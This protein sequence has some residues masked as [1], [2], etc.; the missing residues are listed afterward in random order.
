M[1]AQAPPSA[2][3]EVQVL[4]VDTIPGES[5]FRKTHHYLP[6]RVVDD[7]IKFAI[8]FGHDLDSSEATAFI[9][10]ALDQYTE[11]RDGDGDGD[12]QGDHSD[13][14]GDDHGDDYGNGNDHVPGLTYTPSPAVV[15]KPPCVQA[16][17]RWGEEPSPQAS[18]VPS[19]P[20]SPVNSD[21][22]GTSNYSYDSDAALGEQGLGETSEA[23]KD[24]M[25][26]KV[27]R[28]GEFGKSM[29]SC[30][31]PAGYWIHG[32]WGFVFPQA[33]CFIVKPLT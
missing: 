15:K 1:H 30:E 20:A 13:G 18:P 27:S 10:F 16:S 12:D 3:S 7:V 26:Q 14:D 11:R 6:G 28:T 22:D 17:L 4:H 21:S 5:A 24:R 32:Y 25:M 9:S 19:P 33:P 23:H 2:S 8:S 29:V 31:C